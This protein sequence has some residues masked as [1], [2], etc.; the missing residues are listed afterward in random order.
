MIE[1]N[2]TAF[3][4]GKSNKIHEHSLSPGEY[5]D[6]VDYDVDKDETEVEEEDFSDKDDKSMISAVIDETQAEE[7]D[8]SDKDGHDQCRYR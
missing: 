4:R 3:G 5:D 1:S 8:F 2:P 7:E 6:N